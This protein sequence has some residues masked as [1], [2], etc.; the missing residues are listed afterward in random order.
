MKVK[1]AEIKKMGKVVTFGEIMCRFSPEDHLRFEQVSPGPWQMTFGGAESSVAASVARFGGCS[2]FVTALPDHAI[3]SSCIRQLKSFDVITDHILRSATGRM[4]IYFVERGANQ[5]ASQVI[6]DRATSA[7]AEIY[8]DQFDWVEIF[9]GASWFHT[10]GITPSL[11]EG[12]ALSAI[13]AVKAA[14]EA[15]LTVS[16]D[17]NFRSKLWKWKTG[18]SAEQLAQE[19]MP[20]LMEYTDVVIGNEEDAHKT[21]AI[22]ADDTNVDAGD[23]NLVEFAAAAEAIM[24]RFPNVGTVATTL[25]ESISASH[26]NWGAILSERNRPPVMAPLKAGVYSPYEIRDIVDRVGGGDAFAGALVYALNSGEFPQTQDAL[27]FAT[28]AS[29]LAHSITGDFNFSTREDVERLAAGNGNGRV[30][31]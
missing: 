21:L 10:T 14:K 4:G 30:R 9:R 25:R 13:Q 11:S 15:G 28:A 1:M 23:L 8:P 19:I 6:Y 5:R 27:N 31:R 7:F 22:Q 3:A 24:Q 2:E 29:C 12:A 26:N 17:L 16:V 18:R 20:Q